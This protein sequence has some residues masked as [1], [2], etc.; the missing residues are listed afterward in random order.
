MLVNL[1][2]LLLQLTAILNLISILQYKL[3]KYFKDR[4]KCILSLF[5]SY[6]D[7]KKFQGKDK[8]HSN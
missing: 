8:K 5:S 6:R 3:I 4:P 2:I 7:L 1:I